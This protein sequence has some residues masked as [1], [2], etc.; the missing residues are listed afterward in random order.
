[1]EAEK[2]VEPEKNEMWHFQKWTP[3]A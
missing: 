2:M 1:V 3:C